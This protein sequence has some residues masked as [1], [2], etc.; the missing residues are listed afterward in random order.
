MTDL[1]EDART[2][3]PLADRSTA[4]LVKLAAEQASRLLRDE[5]RLAQ[6]ELTRKGKHVGIGIGLFSGAGLLVVYAVAGL[7]ATAVLALALVLPA[8]LACL[9]VTGALLLTAGLMM[10]IGRVQL[11][12]ASP[13]VPRQAV[14]SVKEDIDTVTEAV[15][16]RGQR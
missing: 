16:D 14:D 10:V 5:L 13:P 3:R 11:K 1:I 8:W 6:G 12:R 7:L 4:E 15:K 9:I 2:T